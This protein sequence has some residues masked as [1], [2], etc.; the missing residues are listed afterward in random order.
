MQMFD[1]MQSLKRQVNWQGADRRS[2]MDLLT[3]GALELDASCGGKGLCGKCK[4]RVLSGDC[5]PPTDEEKHFLTEEDLAAGTR[6]SCC[7]KVRGSITLL[8]PGPE[9]EMCVLENGLMPDVALETTVRKKVIAM[10]EECDCRSLYDYVAGKSGTGAGNP[11]PLNVIRRLG[12]SGGKSPITIVLHGKELIGLECADTT[13]DCYGVALDIGT[14][15]VAAGLIDLYS[16]SDLAVASALNPQVK[17]G[18]DVLSRINKTCHDPEAL[19]NMH[20]LIGACLNGLIE[21]LCKKAGVDYRRIYEVAVAGNNVMLHLLLNVHPGMI[22]RTPYRPVFRQEQIIEA[23]AVGLRI[24]PFGRLLCLPSVSGFIGADIVAGIAASGMDKRDQTALLIDIGTNGEIVL[25]VSG[26]MLACSAAAGPALEGMN[27]ACG[28]RASVGAVDMVRLDGSI[29]WRTVG[30][31]FPRGICGS[32][33][34][35]LVA[36]LLKSG[37]LQPSGRLLGKDE[38]NG[39]RRFWLVPPGEQNNQGVYITQGD[40]RQVQLAKGAIMAGIDMLLKRTGIKE[41]EVEKVYLAG[42]FGFY[43]NPRSIVDIGLLPEIWEDRITP[44]GN[45]SLAGAKMALLSAPAR[46]HLREI[47]EKVDYLELSSIPGFDRN[48]S[49]NMAFPKRE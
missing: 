8:T 9:K 26:R 37:V 48:F 1:P 12:D 14:T 42:A 30:N 11:V 19:K 16:G 35:D 34:I 24:A 33:L 47:A 41:C 20:E 43:A 13:A 18:L 38:V 32:G 45:S 40:V 3:D 2:L 36:V 29:I 46:L 6:L 49:M 10:P 21:E 25:Q 4:V 44:I 17:Y 39:K 31:A 23:A 27:I 22:G 7:C 15:T 5:S 28:M